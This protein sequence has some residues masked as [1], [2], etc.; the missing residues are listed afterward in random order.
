MKPTAIILAAVAAV[1]SS[2]P[3]A[4]A[5][6]AGAFSKGRTSV[7]I[8]GGTGYAF[9]QSYLVLGLG[10]GYYVIDGL[11]LGLSVE[12]WSGSSPKLYKVTPSVQYV[13]HQIPRVSPYIGAFYRRAYVDGLPDINSWGGRAGVYVGAGR[14]AYLGLGAVY[15]SYVD[16]N[17]TLYRSCSETYPE[18]SFIVSF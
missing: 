11:N 2:S 14:N 3:G 10:V 15:E 17:T 5:E 12:S 6:L 1:A 9:D 7:I 13:F 8:T 18:L 4:A 16:C